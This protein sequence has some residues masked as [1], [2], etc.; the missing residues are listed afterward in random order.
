MMKKSP[1]AATPDAYVAA[2]R[3][4][5][6]ELVETLRGAV[7]KSAIF[8]ETIKWGHIVF[9]LNGPAILIRAE[10]ERVLFGFWRGKRLL[11]IEPR[12]KGGG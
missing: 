5:R 3:G 1:P 11:E 12:L 9:F 6:R 10:E 4:W 7:L 8:E 2:L